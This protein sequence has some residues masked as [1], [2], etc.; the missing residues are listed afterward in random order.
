MYGGG[1]LVAKSHPILATLWTVVH[2]IFQAR[3]LES[4]AIS[5]S[6]NVHTGTLLFLLCNFLMPSDVEHLGICFL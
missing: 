2:R 5:F 6:K 3:I 1:R 4:V